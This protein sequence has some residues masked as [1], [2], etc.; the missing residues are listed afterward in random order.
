VILLG[1]LIVILPPSGLKLVFNL[2]MNVAIFFTPLPP[3]V[4]VVVYTPLT[5]P[6]I[7]VV[8]LASKEVY[9]F[10]LAEGYRP[11]FI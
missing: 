10:I 1:E 9:A 6:I 2:T 5:V 4:Y 7:P 11:V 8:T 3:T